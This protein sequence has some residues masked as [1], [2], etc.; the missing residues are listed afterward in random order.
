MSVSERS[1]HESATSRPNAADAVSEAAGTALTPAS[2]KRVLLI[3]NGPSVL[4]RLA[5]PAIDAFDGI[6]ARFNDFRTEGYEAHVGSRTDEWITWDLFERPTSRSYARVLC[7]ARPPADTIGAI[8]ER[9]PQAR[10]L[11]NSVVAETQ[12]L[13]EHAYPS[14]GAYAIMSYV[15]A[16]WDVWLYGFD[17]FA[18]AS[19]H[20]SDHRK[21]DPRHSSNHE[22][23]FIRRL[24]EN[25]RVHI[26]DAAPACAGPPQLDWRVVAA[27]RER[28]IQRLL[29]DVA[30]SEEQRLTWT[31]NAQDL[32]T[33]LEQT[34]SELAA[35]RGLA[36]EYQQ[37]MAELERVHRWLESNAAAD[38]AALLQQLDA[39]QRDRKA[40]AREYEVR[41]RDATGEFRRL[42]GAERAQRERIASD[43]AASA[44]ESRRLGRQLTD[45]RTNFEAIQQRVMAMEST[46]GWR[47]LDR[48]RRALPADSA[49]GR[50]ARRLLRGLARR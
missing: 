50:V 11:E 22:T 14:S 12:R 4:S 2:V 3:G 24:A 44:S 17:C 48:L 13:M 42:L 41:I 29:S 43:F 46:L 45:M 40:A 49:A 23:A 1:Q 38:K 34:R 26:F 27:D 7:T 47:A 39:A 9:Y 5:G 31:K 20:Y 32:A 18:A 8:R 25:G 10:M 30:W 33:E 16:G 21:Q 19:H 15:L 35:A 37:A 28:A 36:A 6:V